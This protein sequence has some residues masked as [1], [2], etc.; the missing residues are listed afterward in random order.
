MARAVDNA[1]RV[2]FAVA[3]GNEGDVTLTSL[4]QSLAMPKAN[5]LRCLR[6]LESHGLV[7]RDPERKVTLGFSVLEL[8]SSFQRRAS[9]GPMSLPYLQRLC[10][11]SGETAALQ[12]ALGCER[13]CIEQVETKAEVKWAV[14]LGRRFP[15]AGGAAGKVLLA[16]QPETVKQMV[17]KSVAEGRF[18]SGLTVPALRRALDGVNRDGFAISIN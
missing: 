15:L 8:S 13:A 3:A 16:Y 10:D 5:V 12:I 4:S 2:L 18:Y 17:M 7:V 1:L 6:D 9:I 14:E 11:A